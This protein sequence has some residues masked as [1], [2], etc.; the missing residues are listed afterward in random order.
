[1]NNP[2]QML[3][4][5]KN[6]QQILQNLTGNN[7]LMQNPM[8]RNAMSMYQNGNTEGLKNMAENICREKGIDPDDAIKQIRS[9]FGM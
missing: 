6:P 5:L 2:F 4:Q 1:M 3:G 9:Q 8:I 7:Q